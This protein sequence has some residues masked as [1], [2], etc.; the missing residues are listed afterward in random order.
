MNL[1]LEFCFCENEL[2]FFSV[3]SD[4]SI[5]EIS[6]EIVSEV[7]KDVGGIYGMIKWWPFVCF[8]ALNEFQKT[9]IIEYAMSI[10]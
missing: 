1:V 10:P 2:P 9:P 7:I 8:R 3:I 6:T 4:K 5:S